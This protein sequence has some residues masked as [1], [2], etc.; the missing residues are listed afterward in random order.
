MSFTNRSLFYI[1]TRD[2]ILKPGRALDLGCG[3]GFDA[4]QLAEAGFIVD[5]VDCDAAVLKT[6][7]PTGSINPLLCRVEN[8][9]ILE[10]AYTLVS[11]QYVLHFLSKEETCDVLRRMIYGAEKGGVISFNLLGEKD[12]WKEKWSTWTGEEIEIF[13]KTFPVNIHKIITEE[14]MGMTRSGQMKYWHV[15]N[16]VLIRK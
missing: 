11:A 14:G 1:L 7:L 9:P 16:Y 15:L 13:L 3:S 6:L 2:G 8:Y 5:A 4:R 10:D 12:G